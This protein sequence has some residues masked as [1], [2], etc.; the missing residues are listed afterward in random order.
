MVVSKHVAPK[1]LL[2]PAAYHDLS[3]SSDPAG[4]QKALMATRLKAGRVKLPTKSTSVISKGP[5]SKT[6]LEDGL[7]TPAVHWHSFDAP[8]ATS[9][10]ELLCSKVLLMRNGTYSFRRVC[11]KSTTRREKAWFFKP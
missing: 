10:Y 3:S 6:G 1:N 11:T 2:G 5:P 7:F 8:G 9:E 4:A